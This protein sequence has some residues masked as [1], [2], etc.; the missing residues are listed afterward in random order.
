MMG[1][2]RVLVQFEMEIDEADLAKLMP[3]AIQVEDGVIVSIDPHASMLGSLGDGIVATV[4]EV[5]DTFS[6]GPYGV[7][8]MDENAEGLAHV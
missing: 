3:N 4:R 5:T 2:K 6:F 1:K 8:D 7:L